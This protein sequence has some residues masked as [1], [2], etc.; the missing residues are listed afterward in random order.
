MEQPVSKQEYMNY[1]IAAADEAWDNLEASRKKWYESIDLNYVFGYNPPPNELYLAALC[2]NIYE[3]NKD[4][5]YL[6]RAKS[7]LQYYDKYRDAY[8]DDFYKTKAEYSN[9]LPVLPNIFSFGKYVHA[10]YKLKKYNRLTKKEDAELRED[11]AHSADYLINFQ[12]WGAMNRA[13]LRA[14]AMLYAAKA[15]PDH[16]NQ[17]K[18]HTLG[19]AIINDNWGQWEIEDASGYNAI[20]LYSLLGYASHVKED[21]SLYR[22]PIMNYYFEYFLQLMSPAGIIPDFGD[23][24]WGHS[25]N[26]Y[27]PF[28]EKG[29]AVYNDPRL[30]WAAA[31]YFRKYLDPMPERKSVFTALCLSDAYLWA[32]FDLGAERP[33]GGSREVLEDMIGKK[34]I[35]RNGWQPNSTYLLYNYRD[36]GDG[37]WLYREYLRTSI[38]VEEEKMHHGH[39]DENSVVLLMKNNSVLLH[40]G[41]Y[42]DYMPSG[43]YGQFRADYFHNRIAV[44]DGKIALG[45][46]EGQYRYASPNREAVPGQSMLDFFRNS[47]AYRPVRTQKIDFLELKHFDMTRTRVIDDNLGY[48]SDRIITYVKELD[49]FVIFDVVKF[50]KDTYLTL[51]NLWHTR[52]IHAQGPGWYVT[53]YDSL[54]NVDVAGDEHL[55]IHFPYRERLEEG[56]ESLQRYYQQEQAIYQMIGRHGYPGDLQTFV[57]VL[58]PHGKE[59][60]A[61]KL[62]SQIEMLDV[63]SFPEAVGLTIKSGEKK[64]VIAAKLD[65]QAEIVRDWRRPK[66]TYDSGKT[67]Y[68]DYET[69]AYNLFAVET[70]DKIHYAMIGA[71][72]I[73]Y[74]DR[75]LHEQFP[76][77][78]GLNFDGSPDQPGVGK[79]RYWEQEVSK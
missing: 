75:V 42:R 60:D 15:L 12:E 79:L 45:Q 29:A 3:I 47:G 26:R 74:K 73:K 37:G 36:E 4:E 65:L 77:D 35:F 19:Q 48:Q 8:P 43:P 30:R 6:D 11:I 70:A 27:L 67:R 66:Y 63:D 71:V 76:A 2:V 55:L 61:K 46:R 38:P 18:W 17:P 5:K 44:R 64:Y 53:S 7:L 49:W 22:T 58:V 40:D 32:D 62:A 1:I 57:T 10:Y 59:E 16:P 14:E 20:W 31:Q 56:V 69:D 51:A 24:N 68:G 13:M 50:T 72:K 54:N 28:F 33:T 25:W 39:A 52:Q 41:G 9:G 34:V 21:E 78:F 23:A